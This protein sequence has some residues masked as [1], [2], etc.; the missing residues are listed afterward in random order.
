LT[1]ALSIQ[2]LKPEALGGIQV[3]LILS[4]A[5]ILHRLPIPPDDRGLESTRGLRVRLKL[6]QIF[7]SKLDFHDHP[8]YHGFF[9]MFNT[10]ITLSV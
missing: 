1:L 8:I 2:L 9:W 10:I 3:T 5:D 6:I 7:I 4:G